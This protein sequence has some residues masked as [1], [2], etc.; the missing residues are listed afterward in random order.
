M[1]LFFKKS[2]WKEYLESPGTPVFVKHYVLPASP[3]LTADMRN[4]KTTE[5]CPNLSYLPFW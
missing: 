4:G 3:V 1:L 5:V 2:K